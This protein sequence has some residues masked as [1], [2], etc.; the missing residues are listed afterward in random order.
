MYYLVTLDGIS[1]AVSTTVT[2]LGVIFYQDLSF[3]L[4][5]KQ[6]SRT[7]FFHL[8]NIAKIR[9]ILSQ[10]CGKL[11]HAFVTSRLENCNS[12]LLGCPKNSLKSLFSEI[13]QLIQNAAVRV[14]IKASRRDHISPVLLTSVNLEDNLK[15]FSSEVTSS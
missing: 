11:L 6:V 9:N 15:L 14:L 8:H 7:D 3:H 13:F 5:I 1:L 4:R 12:L 2:S 10:C